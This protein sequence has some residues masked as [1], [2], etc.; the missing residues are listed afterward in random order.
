MET[1]SP[2]DAPKTP[3]ADLGWT[4]RAG[5]LLSW[6]TRRPARALKALWGRSR[7]EAIMAFCEECCG[8]SR[9]E[10]RRCP[11]DDCPLWSFR[12]GSSP[13]TSPPWATP[14]LRRHLTGLLQHPE[15]GEGARA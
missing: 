3:S 1:K 15:N 14:A 8:G 13:R 5:A 6:V 12:P 11:A 2:Q 7:R 4:A 10:A 9:H